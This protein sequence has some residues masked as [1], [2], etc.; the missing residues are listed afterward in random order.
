LRYKVAIR[1]QVDGDLR[2]ISHHDTMRLFERALSR[3]QLPVKFSEGFNPRPRISLPLPRPVGVATLADMLVIEL[4]ESV[5]APQVLH[6][7]AEQMPGGLTLLEAIELD[8]GRKL[9]PEQV[10]YEVALP[11]DRALAVRTAVERVLAAEQWPIERLDEHGKSVRSIDLRSLLVEASVGPG[12]LR[13]THRVPDGGSARCGE[14]LTALGLD[15]RE[16]LHRV[17][18]TAVHWKAGTPAGL[19]PE[20]AATADAWRQMTGSRPSKPLL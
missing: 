13:W 5:E 6:R 3:A 7:L 8:A 19:A 11:E 20:P 2:F 4:R 14:W 12:V 9:H 15:G 16:M 1:F 17:R 10:A 18:R